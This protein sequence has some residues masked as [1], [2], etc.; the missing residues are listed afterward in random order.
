MIFFYYKSDLNS[1]VKI[2]NNLIKYIFFQ[3]NKKEDDKYAHMDNVH[4][5][6]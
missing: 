4:F 1:S 6:L 5:I 3:G 2:K